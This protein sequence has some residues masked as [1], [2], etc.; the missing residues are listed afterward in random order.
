M[1]SLRHNLKIFISWKSHAPSLNN[2]TFFILKHSINSKSY[3]LMMSNS[4][5]TRVM[6]FGPLKNIVI[7]KRFSKYI[8]RFG[9]LGPKSRPL[10]IYQSTTINQE[11]I[12]ISLWLLTFIKVCTETGAL[13][14]NPT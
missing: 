6:K 1:K 5:R 14:C 11:T 3:D 10:L 9:D 13:P 2:S 7:V 8:A 4:T 12:M